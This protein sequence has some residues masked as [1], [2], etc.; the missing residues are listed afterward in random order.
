MRIASLNRETK[1][2]KIDVNVN[3]DGNGLSNIKTDIGFFN[4]MLDLL[5]FHSLIDL[6]IKASGDTDV[7]DHHL[8]EDTGILIG[9]ALLQALGDKKGINRYGTF[10]MPMDETLAMVSLDISGRAYLH[11]D[12]NFKRES[13]GDFSTEM[14]VEFFRAIAMN[15]GLTL[16]IKVLYGENDHHK[17][18]AIFKAFGRVLKEAIKI[19]NGD[20][21]PSS[22]GVL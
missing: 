13:I 5:S 8:I 4:H 2:T 10:F 17:I 22:K 9:K 11:F 19:E 14:V 20:K 15:S 3:L 7:C 21:I 6:D 1:E 18:E 16:H 12:A